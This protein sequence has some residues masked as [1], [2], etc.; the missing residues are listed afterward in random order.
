MT[1]REIERTVQRIVS[2]LV[3]MDY[4]AIERLTRGQRLSAQGIR[5]A[6]E[7]YG[8]RLVMPPPEKL[9]DLDVIEVENVVPRQWSV[10]VDLWTQEEGR[11]D[12]SLELTLMEADEDFDVEIDNIHVM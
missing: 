3:A 12:L 7:E 5:E 2:L 11:S 9:Q 1:S 8:R 6:I 4:Q 10:R